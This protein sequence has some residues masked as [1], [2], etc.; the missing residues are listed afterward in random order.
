[1]RFAASSQNKPDT[2]VVSLITGSKLVYSGLPFAAETQP[3]L[4]RENEQDSVHTGIRVRE[5]QDPTNSIRYQS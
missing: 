4:M 1:M 3:C 2:L 5:S